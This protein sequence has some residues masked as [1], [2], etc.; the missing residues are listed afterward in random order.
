MAAE[1]KERVFAA[2]KGY[3]LA[4]AEGPAWAQFTRDYDREEPNGPAV[5]SFVT[6]DAKVAARLLKAD[7]D[8]QITEVTGAGGNG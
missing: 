5:F 6:S 3:I 7:A 2:P 8:H 4:D 1:A